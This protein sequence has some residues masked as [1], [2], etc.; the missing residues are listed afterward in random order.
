MT[1]I[2]REFYRAAR[3][4]TPSDEDWWTLILD[5]AS[6]RLFVRH[7][8][9]APRHSG[10]DEF[11]IAEFLSE[12]GAARDALVDSVFRVPADV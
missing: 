11:E 10:V 4:P 12:E 9:Q 1:V 8:W 5:R 2:Q 6:G 7:E 3:G